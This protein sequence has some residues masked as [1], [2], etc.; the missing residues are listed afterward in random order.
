MCVRALG[1]RDLSRSCGS[2]L[3]MHNILI[4]TSSIHK[5]HVQIGHMVVLVINVRLSVLNAHLVYEKHFRGPLAL[6]GP[7][8][9]PTFA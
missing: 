8:Q 7:R 6:G 1:K 2:Q 9:S 3:Q 4:A 5:K